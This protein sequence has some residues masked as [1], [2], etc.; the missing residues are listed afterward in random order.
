MPALVYSGRCEMIKMREKQQGFNLIELMIVVAIIAILA[1]VAFPAYKKSVVSSNRAAAQG[2]LQGMAMA[3]A[4]YRSQNF[5][6]NGANIDTIYRNKS[7][8]PYD[9]SFSSS[10]NSNTTAQT[11]IIFAKPKSSTQQ[12]NDGAL[13]ID[14]AGNRCWN[15]SS[16]TTCTP[17]DSGQKW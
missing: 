3:M 4:T 9:Y 6:Y 17:G 1:S 8:A 5:T 2:D 11:F 10:G 15:K 12:K 14:Q 7:T 13:G 16:D